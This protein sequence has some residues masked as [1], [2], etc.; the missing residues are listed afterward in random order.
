MNYKFKP[1]YN[2]VVIKPLEESE[3]IQGNI[4]IPNAGNE[5]AHLATVI[6]IGPGGMTHSGIRIPTEAEIGEIVLYPGF[7][8]QKINL[9]NQEYYIFKDTDLLSGVEEQN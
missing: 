5:G 7:G 3:Q 2:Q 1:K 8:G 4:I 6:A 9:N